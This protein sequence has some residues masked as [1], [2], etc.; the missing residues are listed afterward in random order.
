M[1]YKR[2][3]F[4]KWLHEVKECDITPLTGKSAGVILIKNWNYKFYLEYDKKDR[5]DY[6]EI[7]LACSKLYI[8]GLPGD[9]DLERIE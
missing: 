8:D 4:V 6:E 3:S 5:I 9:S 1:L 7:Y 2:S